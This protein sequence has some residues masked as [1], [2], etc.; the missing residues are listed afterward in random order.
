MGA[1]EGRGPGGRGGDIPQVVMM[2]ETAGKERAGETWLSW[3]P[4][5]CHRRRRRRPSEQHLSDG[6]RQG[7]GVKSRGVEVR[8]HGVRHCRVDNVRGGTPR[9]SDH[10]PGAEGPGAG[11]VP[12]AGGGGPRGRE[13]PMQGPRGA[14][15]ACEAAVSERLLQGRGM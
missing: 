1:G 4:G 12:A 10:L 9:A 15:R 5:P 2:T 13:G 14:E 11:A 8:P 7:P 6:E 3:I